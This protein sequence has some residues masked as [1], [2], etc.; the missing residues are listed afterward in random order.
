M[1]SADLVGIDC[2]V[3]NKFWE[4]RSKEAK[5]SPRCTNRDVVTLSEECRQHTAAKTRYQVDD[6]NAHCK[7]ENWSQLTADYRQNQTQEVLAKVNIA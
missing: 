3:H 5:Q 7:P 4:H 1:L 6:P 2:P